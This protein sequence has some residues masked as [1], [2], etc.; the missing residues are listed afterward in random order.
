MKQQVNAAQRVSGVTDLKNS[1]TSLNNAMDQ[2]KQAIGDHDTIV[3][4]GNYTNASPD[5]QGAYT[6]AYNAA[7]NIVNG[8]PNVITNA[9]DV[10]AATQ[11]VN[12]AETSLNGDTNLATAKQQAKDALRQMTHLSDAQKQS[13]TGQID[14]A[15]QVTGVQS[16]KDNAT[17]LDNAMNQLRNSIANKDEVKASQPYVDADTDK[18]NAYNTAVTSAENIINATSQPTLDPSAVTQAANQVNTN[19]TALNGAQT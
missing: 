4:G 3:A 7:K 19:K 1:A 13:I 12:N 11:R 15:T 8:S 9:A 14:S 5:K 6:D 17:N 2:L 16:V 10:T 18:Q